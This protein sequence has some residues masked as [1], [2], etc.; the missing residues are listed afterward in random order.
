MSSRYAHAPCPVCQASGAYPDEFCGCGFIAHE[1]ELISAAGGDRDI[2]IAT[3]Q[4]EFAAWW[5]TALRRS[6]Q[7]FDDLPFCVSADKGYRI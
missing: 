3:A 1:A 7:M 6:K 4:Q 2:A 5:Q